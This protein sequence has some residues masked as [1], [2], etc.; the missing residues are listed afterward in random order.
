MASDLEQTMVHCTVCS[1]A[2]V[3]KDSGPTHLSEPLK[4]THVSEWLTT[5][6][7]RQPIRAI[8]QLTLAESFNHCVPYEKKG[9]RWTAVT[10]AVTLHI[11][12]DIGN[13]HA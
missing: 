2:V 12:K 1:K 9:S 5:R 10:D 11:G 8:K 4:Q 7:P 6:R 3:I 13:K